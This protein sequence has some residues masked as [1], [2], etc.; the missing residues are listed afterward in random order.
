MTRI[1]LS[2]AAAAIFG[3]PVAAADPDPSP[4]V[5]YQVPSPSGPVLPGNEQLPPVCAHAMQT[6]GYSLDPGTMTWQP[7]GGR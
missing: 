3:A 2:L 7:R 4:S 5:P 1:L 6:C